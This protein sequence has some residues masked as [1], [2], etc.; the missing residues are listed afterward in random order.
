MMI[1]RLTI[2]WDDG[3]ESIELLCI[4]QEAVDEAL[5]QLAKTWWKKEWDDLKDSLEGIKI[6]DDKAEVTRVYF[7][8]MTWKTYKVEDVDV[9][10]AEDIA[11]NYL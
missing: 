4:N 8:K 9:W 3:S 2:C 5:Y 6:P 7:E 10:T 1:K 11:E